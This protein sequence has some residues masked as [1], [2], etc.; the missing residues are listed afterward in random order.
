MA[1]CGHWVRHRQT[2]QLEVRARWWQMWWLK[3]SQI[4]SSRT[5]WEQHK[6]RISDPAKLVLSGSCC[7]LDR[8]GIDCIWTR[9]FCGPVNCKLNS[10]SSW[11]IFNITQYSNRRAINEHHPFA[12]PSWKQKPSQSQRTWTEDYGGCHRC[13]PLS[14]VTSELSPDSDASF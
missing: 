4:H 13:V 12:F 9:G 2:R 8:Y 3:E 11:S 10:L 6:Y 5:E 1:D 14:Q 7:S